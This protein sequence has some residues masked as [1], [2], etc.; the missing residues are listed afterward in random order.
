MGSG[1]I[2]IKHF[3][4]NDKLASDPGTSPGVWQRLRLAD[5]SLLMVGIRKSCIQEKLK[6]RFP[7]CVI[8]LEWAAASVVKRL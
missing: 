8:N 2:V 3:N 6:R 4:H 1:D 7:A 5:V